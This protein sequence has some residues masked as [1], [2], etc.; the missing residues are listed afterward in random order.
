MIRYT[1]RQFR[2][3][4]KETQNHERTTMWAINRTSGDIIDEVAFIDYGDYCDVFVTEVTALRCAEEF[5]A[6]CEDGYFENIPTDRET[7]I[8][9]DGTEIPFEWCE[10]YG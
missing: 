6:Q 1:T 5:I 8:L 7:E 10:V 9:P 3:Y 2:T 4:Y